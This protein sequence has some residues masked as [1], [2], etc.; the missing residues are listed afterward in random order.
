MEFQRGSMVECYCNQS[1]YEGAWFKALVIHVAPLKSSD[2]CRTIK[3]QYDAFETEDKQPLTESL[4]YN[5]FRPIPPPMPLPN[6]L[7]MGDYVETFHNDCWWRAIV[8]DFPPTTPNNAP[9][10][11]FLYFPDTMTWGN[12][13]VKDLRPCQEW[14]R[15]TW[16]SP[17]KLGDREVAKLRKMILVRMTEKIQELQKGTSKASEDQI[18]RRK[19]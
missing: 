1:G 16:I 11:Y 6:N 15:G 7:A 17:Q 10:S 19:L 13:R 3:V 18:H 4:C 8:L 12:Y 9:H 2:G 5:H 14:V